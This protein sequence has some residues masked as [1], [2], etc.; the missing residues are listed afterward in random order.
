VERFTSVIYSAS[1]LVFF[2]RAHVKTRLKVRRARK[3]TKMITS[4][5]CDIHCTVL[6][7]NY[8]IKLFAWKYFY[9]DPETGNQPGNIS[10]I[11]LRHETSLEILQK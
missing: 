1:F 11:I 9:N 3:E 4:S 2:Y 7:K 6:V 8:V 5:H 10:I